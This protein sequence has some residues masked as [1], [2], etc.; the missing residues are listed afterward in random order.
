MSFPQLVKEMFRDLVGSWSLARTIFARD[1]KAE[2]RASFLGIVWAFIMPFMNAIIWAFLNLTGVIK[3]S[4]TG[5]PYPLFVFLGTMIWGVF[6][7]CINLPSTQ[8][9]SFLQFFK[10]QNIAKE[11]SIVSG[12]LSQLW[13]VGFQLIIV[14]VILIFYGINPGF[15]FIPF[16]GMILFTIFFGTAIG[17]YIFPITYF[18][19]DIGRIIPVGF[20]FLMYATPVVYKTARF[21]PLQKFLDI[22]PLSPLINTTRNFAVG[23]GFDNLPYLLGIFIVSVILFFFGWMLYRISIPI[24]V[25]R[26]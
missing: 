8:T 9:N 25:E 22:N 5:M 11:T 12:I 19:K 13:S 3:I 1:R 6:T 17:F 23:E 2:Y 24:I 7:N 16:L 15:Y 26:S 4:D 21:K 20:S 10:T 18:F 14:I